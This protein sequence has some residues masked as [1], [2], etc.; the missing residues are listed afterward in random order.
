[1]GDRAIVT[2]R[3]HVKLSGGREF[4]KFSPCIYLHWAGRRVRQLLEK[5][6]PVLRT[7]D[8]SYAAAR[9]CGV[10]HAEEHE[11]G[12]SIGLSH[13]PKDLDE[14]TSEDFSHGDAG[15]FIVDV[16]TW[17]VTCVNG[18]GFEDII[19][20]EPVPADYDYEQ[21]RNWDMVFHLDASKAFNG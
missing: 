1:M 11:S 18:Y 6:L 12:L 16:D 14:A 8:E 4:D 20:G 2:F 17:I 13:A 9:F 5:A 19:D 3:H 10:C 7:G 21:D 15:V